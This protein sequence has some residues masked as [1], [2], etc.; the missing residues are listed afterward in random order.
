MRK[1]E[2][3]YFEALYNG[4]R[5]QKHHIAKIKFC[6]EKVKFDQPKSI[7]N[8]WPFRMVRRGKYPT[9]ILTAEEC[10]VVS[11]LVFRSVNSFR[12]GFWDISYVLSYER[13]NLDQ[14]VGRE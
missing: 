1:I 7:M 5:K 12:Y 8:V 2:R 9:C 13:V 10:E 6:F 3:L 4:R 11:F 14:L